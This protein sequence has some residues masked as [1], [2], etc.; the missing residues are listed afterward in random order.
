MLRKPIMLVLP[1]LLGALALLPTA[2][3]AQS[4]GPGVQV[5]MPPVG[6]SIE[7]PLLAQY[8]GAGAC[9]PPALVAQLLQLGSPPLALAGA[10]QDETSP[11]GGAPA[12][13]GPSWAASTLYS[14]PASFWSQLHCLLSATGDPLTVGLNMKTGQLSWAQ[15]MVAGAQSAATNGLDF[16]LGNEPD[17]YSLPNYASLSR[18][19]GNEEAIAVN[20]YL[21]QGSYLQQALGGA[22]VIGPEL[23]IAGRW[24]HELPRII[25]Q[26]HEQTVGVHLYPLTACGSA[27]TATIDEL[28]SANAAGAP[29]IRLKINSVPTTGTVIVVARASTARNSISMRKRL[30]PR[31]SPTSGRTEESI[32]GRYNTATARIQRPPRIAVGAIS[33]GLIPSTSPNS[34]E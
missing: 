15:Q 8:L 14:L 6:L 22:P 31:A 23:A 24:R 2:A 12:G 21:Q 26:L 13:P 10:S 32:S 18:P 11:S 19:Q 17:L 33:F 5:T 9:P 25:G 27:P 4:S 30:T 3:E 7:Y 34:S 20:R 28:L 16:S 29:I 1:L